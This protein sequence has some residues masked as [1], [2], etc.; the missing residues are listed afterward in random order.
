MD[1]E[2]IKQTLLKLKQELESR[3]E[4][5]HRHIYHKDKPV[6][7][8]FN[9]QIKEKEND[10]LVMALEADGKEELSMI[11]RALKRIEDGEYTE[12]AVCGESIAEARLEAIPYADRC[13]NCASKS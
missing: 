5:T 2:S 1:I 7:A 11:N 3:L 9:E 6:S 12:C 8:N 10:E 13:I 4:R